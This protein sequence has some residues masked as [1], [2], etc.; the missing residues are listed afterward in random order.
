MSVKR[1]TI[2]NLVG[3]GSPLLVAIFSIPFLLKHLGN[4]GFGILTLIWALIGYFTLFDFGIGRALTYEL[5][6]RAGGSEQELSPY[7][8]AGLLLTLGTGLLGGVLVASFAGLL[9]HSWLGIRG[10]WQQDAYFALLIAAVGIVPTTL[11]SGLRGALEGLNRFGTSNINKVVVGCLTVA[12][13][14]WSVAF[15]GQQIWIATLYIVAVRFIFFFVLVFQLRAFTF[16]SVAVHKAHFRS[17]FSYGVWLSVTGTLGPLMVYGDRF[18]VSAWLGANLLPFYTI[19]QEMLARLLIL[20]LSFTGALLPKLAA[21]P[22]SDMTV[23][24][25]R[26]LRLI[27]VGMFFVCM[28]VGALAY[29]A[30]KIWISNDFAAEAI[31]VTLILLLG[32]WFNS[33]ALVPYTAIHALGNTRLTAILHILELIV[34]IPMVWYLANNYGILGVAFAWTIR[35]ISD[36]A[37]LS[38]F[39]S[40]LLKKHTEA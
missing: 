16:S 31:S 1:N 34:Y 37:L 32:V 10:S 33:L 36:F 29:P 28:I 21:L 15:H 40:S 8:K 13:P 6:R 19:P 27:A 39:A 17:L 4:E 25:R 12:L 38:I 23:T 22:P 35:V 9:S 11:T 24:Y 20:P 3:T 14:A 2:W 30:L 7:L 26:S 18:L 5:G